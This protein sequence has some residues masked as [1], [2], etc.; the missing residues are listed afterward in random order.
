MVTGKPY[1]LEQFRQDTALY[2]EV[3]QHLYMDHGTRRGMPST[4]AK[5]ARAMRALLHGSINPND[6]SIHPDIASCLREAHTSGYV[7][8]DGTNQYTFASPLHQQLWSWHLLPPTDYQLP[9][10]DLVSFVTDTVSRFSPSQLD[11]SDRRVGSASH[12]PPEARYQEEYYRCVHKLTE[13]N[14]RIS[15]E[16]AAA[17][18]SRPGRIHFFIPSKKWGIELTRD[19]DNLSEHGAR[20]PDGDAYGQWLQSLDMTDYV[21][22][23]FRSTMPAQ[24]HPGKRVVAI[25]LDQR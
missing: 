6:T 15:P 25:S 17:A 2:S 8:M 5:Y 7:D 21:L 11:K 22:L 4:P 10:Q 24:T 20:F 13:G 12:R 14:V 18:G 1:H 23:D 19:G 3:C 9:Y 16:Y